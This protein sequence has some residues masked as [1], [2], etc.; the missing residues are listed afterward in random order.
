VSVKKDAPVRARTEP[1]RVVAV[2]DTIIGEQG[3]VAIIGRDL[4]R[5]CGAA[6]FEEAIDLFDNVDRMCSS[7]AENRDAIR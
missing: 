3:L 5:V 1:Y 7:T 2:G 4:A 6:T